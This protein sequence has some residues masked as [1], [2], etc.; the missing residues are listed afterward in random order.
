MKLLPFDSP[1]FP[2]SLKLLIPFFEDVF[3]LA[4]QFVR[5]SD[6]ADGAVEPNGVV[7]RDVLCHKSPGIVKRKRRLRTDAFSF[8]RLVKTFQ[9]A[10]RLRIVRRCSYVSHAGQPNEFF[11][12]LGNELR[13]VVRDDPGASFWKL[14]FCPLND[15][16][17]V[18]FQHPFPDF[19]MDDETA[20]AVKK[21]AQV[22][23]RATDVEIRNIHMP[24]FVRLKRLDKAGSFFADLFVPLVQ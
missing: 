15:D 22:V 20:A 13:T 1:L 16:F 9:L 21:A 11:K 19:P 17:Y 18:G 24:V 10:V 23:K 7:T 4:V 14:L 3:V 8:E 2:G 6:V 5:R 12:I